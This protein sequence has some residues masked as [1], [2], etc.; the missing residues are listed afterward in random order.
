M[1]VAVDS[2]VHVFQG[3]ILKAENF[4]C[5]VV[6][7]ESTVHPVRRDREDSHAPCATQQKAKRLQVVST[8]CKTDQKVDGSAEPGSQKVEGC[9]EPGYPKVERSLEPGSQKVE[10]SAELETETRND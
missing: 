1:R 10:G 5:V 9:A 6:R 3:H 4:L 7:D 8:A 2:P